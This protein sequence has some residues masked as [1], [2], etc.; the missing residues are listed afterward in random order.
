MTENTNKLWPALFE[1]QKEIGTM[2]KDAVNPFYNSKYIPLPEL[3]K[4]VLPLLTARRVL[5]M[6]DV[7]TSEHGPVVVTSFRHLDS[8][9]VTEDAYPVVCADKA[10][11]Q[12]F[13][14]GV[15][16]ARRYGLKARLAIIELD[17]DGN[18]A[19]QRPAQAPRIAQVPRSPAPTA[20]R[21]GGNTPAYT[22]STGD[23]PP[24]GKRCPSCGQESVF[25]SKPEKGG[26]WYCWKK[27]DPIKCCGTKYT[28]SVWEIVKGDQPMKGNDAPANV[29]NDDLSNAF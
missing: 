19:S 25:K 10:N 2:T 22:P 24:K 11:P 26:G 29:S 18:L 9:E 12:A 4:V 16:Y 21:S 28:D 6:Q 17:D 5:L 27:V 1:V 8:G 23:A 3:L 7:R 15:S 13:G 20:P 14:T